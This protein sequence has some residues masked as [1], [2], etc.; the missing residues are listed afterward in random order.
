[1]PDTQKSSTEPLSK[2]LPAEYDGPALGRDD[3]VW[4]YYLRESES[5]DTELIDGWNNSCNDLGGC[6]VLQAAL[7]SAIVTAF[8]IESHKSLQPD[9]AL[10]IAA[11]VSR[12]V[13]IIEAR[14]S[15]EPAPS[16]APLPKLDDFH[17]SQRD[18]VVNSLWFFSLA[19]SMLVTLLAMLVKEWANVYRRGDRFTPYYVQARTRQARYDGL[20]DWGAKFVVRSLPVLM[21][22]ALGLFLLGLVI[23]LDKPKLSSVLMQ[24]VLLVVSITL[25]LYLIMTF[26]PLFSAFCPFN[27]PL[28]NRKA[29]RFLKSGI[30]GV[31]RLGVGED[32]FTLPGERKERTQS[33]STALDKLAAQ[34]VVWLVSY[35][36]AEESVDAGTRAIADA[37]AEH[38]FWN[39]LTEHEVV[40]L[41]A[42][43]FTSF[44]KGTLGRPWPEDV[45]LN[46]VIGSDDLGRMSLC[47]RALAKLAKRSTIQLIQ[48][49]TPHTAISGREEKEPGCIMLSEAHCISVQDGLH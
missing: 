49:A 45:S 15:S 42:Q 6:A 28:S 13:D 1:M 20:E 48:A 33:T 47:S 10:I 16:G 43:R 4:P 2:S 37:L 30:Y 18:I 32:S 3:P 29:W 19:L 17:P 40:T 35:S 7:F 8:L 14:A 23:F 24:L 38:G 27:T 26:L 21:H 41:M 31:L 39:H 25:F 5:R 12:M 44:F 46:D 36:Q 11:G 9:T 22:I 34:A